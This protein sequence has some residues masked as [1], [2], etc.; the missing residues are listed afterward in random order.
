[1]LP[2]WRT[3]SSSAQWLMTGSPGVLAFGSQ[4]L[5]GSQ[6]PSA[7]TKTKS[8]PWWSAAWTSGRRKPATVPAASMPFRTVRRLIP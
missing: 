6:P 3:S 2:A 1:M 4:K 8:F 7:W 5:V